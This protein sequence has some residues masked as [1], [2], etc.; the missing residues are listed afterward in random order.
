MQRRPIVTEPVMAATRE[1]D[2]WWD[3]LHL[4][5][6]VTQPGNLTVTKRPE[7]SLGATACWSESLT[8]S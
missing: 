1:F 8:R 3:G 2:A 6:A 5:P 7:R 4:V